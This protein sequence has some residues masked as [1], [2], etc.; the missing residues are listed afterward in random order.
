MMAVT[1][2]IL[3]Y[4]ERASLGLEQSQDPRQL[5]HGLEKS[6]GEVLSCERPDPSLL[7]QCVLLQPA[8]DVLTLCKSIWWPVV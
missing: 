5:T 7:P 6:V 1:K 8:V 2:V 3:I 4:G